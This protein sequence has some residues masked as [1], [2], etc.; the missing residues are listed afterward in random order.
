MAVRKKNRSKPATEI[1]SVPDVEEVDAIEEVR[2]AFE[3]PMLP[4]RAEP[5]PTFAGWVARRGLL[6]AIIFG[7]LL[8]PQFVD[9]VRENMISFALVYVVIGLSIN[10]LIGYAG[11]ISLGHQAF[12]GVGA[13]T[14]AYIVS[15]S[16]LSFWIGLA[17]A[18]L[19]GAGAALLLGLV[20]LRL[21]GLYLALITLAYGFVAQ[22]SIFNIP[23][24]TG[25][26]AGA[27]APRP[28]GFTGNKAFV[29]LC[30]I[31][32]AVLMYVD[33]RL[34]RSKV[35]RA[36]FAIRENELAAA[37]F[38]INVTAY[39]LIAFVISGVFA[40]IGG[41]LFAHRS[42]VVVSADFNFALAL[43]FVL[44]VVVGG[45]GSRVGVFIGSAFFALFPLIFNRFSKYTGLIGALLLLL[46]L[47]TFPGG[48]AQQIAPIL[49]WFGGAPLRGHG[50]SQVIQSGGAGVRP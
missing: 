29:Y 39:K 32:L 45:L 35:G 37:S 8:A 11:Q 33:W 22:N 1:V 17:L 2:E 34:V 23:A 4:V 30:F 38:G 6:A 18:G 42:T 20:A 12:V 21:R 27:E 5:G 46:T 26:G 10:I 9:N 24:L 50:K 28:A 15:N 43:T 19:T 31:I 40:G 7:V 25:G 48:I 16:H 36:I 13:F 47:T 41:S 3:A 49:R 14:S 44:M